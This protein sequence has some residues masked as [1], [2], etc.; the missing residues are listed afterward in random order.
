MDASKKRY[1]PYSEVQGRHADMTANALAQILEQSASYQ[2]SVWLKFHKKISFQ[3]RLC[4]ATAISV[5][6]PMPWTVGT[7]RLV[8]AQRCHHPKKCRSH[9]HKK[10]S[11]QIRL[12]WATAI[13]VIWPMPWTVGTPRLV[14]AQRCH[15]PKKCRSHLQLG[16][17][18]CSLLS[19]GPPP[20]SQCAYCRTE[21]IMEPIPEGW[22]TG[23]SS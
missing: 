15:H 12:C 2:I 22:S 13:S 5:I 6:W 1:G 17:S 7:P 21:C 20:G 11:F 4:W 8:V 9:L 10:I 14:V 18:W 16:S 23:L 3:I 19:I